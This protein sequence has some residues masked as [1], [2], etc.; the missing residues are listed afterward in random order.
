MLQALKRNKHLEVKAELPYDLKG[1]FLKALEVNPEFSEAHLQL[2]LIYGEENN[3]ESA[4]LHFLQAIASDTKQILDIEKHGNQ[5]LK[6]H[7]FQNAKDQFMKA[8]EKKNHCAEVNY[9]LAHLYQQKSKLSKAQT[10]LEES[11]ALNPAFFNIFSIILHVVD[12][13]LVPVI[14]II[15]AS[16][17]ISKKIS[18]SVIIFFMFFFK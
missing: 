17:L 13:P 6:N 18:R 10:C 12:F 15:N 3:E 2:A 5:L 16:L 14:E 8:Q 11:I 4:E 9:F 7:Q 1:H